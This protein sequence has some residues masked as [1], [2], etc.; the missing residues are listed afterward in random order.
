MWWHIAFAVLVIALVSRYYPTRRV[1]GLVLVLPVISVAVLAWLSRNPFNALGFTVLAVLLLRAASFLPLTTVMPASSGWVLAGA[2]LLAVGWTYP[3]FLITDTWTAYIYASPFGLLPCP[4]LS[5]V[6]GITLMFGGLHSMAWSVP[7]FAAGVLYG[8][9]GVFILEVSLDVWLLSGSILLG[10]MVAADRPG[11]RVRATNSEQSRRLP[12]DELVP[13]A[14]GTLTHAISIAGSPGAVWPWLVQMGA[15]SRA[16]WYSYDFVDN[17]RQASE[18]RIVPEL[19]HLTVG[20]VL[21]ALPGVTEGFVVLALEPRRFLILGWPGPDGSPLVTWAFVLEEHPGNTTRLIVRVR[22]GQGYRFHGLP[23]WLSI[24]A[25]RLVHFVMQRKQLLGIVRRVEG[26]R[27]QLS[28]NEDSQLS[29]VRHRPGRGIEVFHV[30]QPAVQSPDAD[31][32]ARLG[33]R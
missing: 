4:T 10:V 13:D 25:I 14:V 27:G 1:L 22:G 18:M 21:P 24:P 12:G 6:M 20:T 28:S 9:I 17:G 23:E 16:G 7:L 26:F 33:R 32:P 5:V 3:H 29:P 8:L 15:G 19:Q 11:R 30:R 2:G 31:V